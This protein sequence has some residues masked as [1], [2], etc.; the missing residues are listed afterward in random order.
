M[1]NP[2]LSDFSVI[3][4]KISVICGNSPEKATIL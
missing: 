4:S 1:S 3:D 2:E